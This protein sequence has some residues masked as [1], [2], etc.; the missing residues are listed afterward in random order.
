MLSRM[1]G[2]Q[3]PEVLGVLRCVERGT[4]DAQVHEQV[5]IAKKKQGP[6]DLLKLFRNDDTWV[7]GK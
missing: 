6:G 1:M 3:F 2:P 4:Y 7:V 5:D